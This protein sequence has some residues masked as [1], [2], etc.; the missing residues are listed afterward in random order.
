MKELAEFTH[1]ALAVIGLGLWLGY[2]TSHD[3]VLAA[4]GLGILLGAICAGVSWFVVNARAARRAAAD[5]AAEASGAEPPSVSPRLLILHA[6]GATLTL[7]FVILI[8]VRA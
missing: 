6:V 7:L 1:P 8:T 4:I 2:V 5:G 3:R